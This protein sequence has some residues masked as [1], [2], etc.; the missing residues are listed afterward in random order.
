MKNEMTVFTRP[1]II[2]G[3]LILLAFVFYL[4]GISHESLWCD[5]A[6]SANMAEFGFLDIIKN[7]ALDVHPP[8]Y[9]ILLRIFRLALGNSEW[10]LRLISVFSAV[11]MIGLGA[12]PVRRLFGNKTAY[13][14]AAAV[15]FTP[16]ILIWAHEVRMYGP[17]I[18]TT[19]TCVLY[20]LSVL[21]ENK[22]RYWILFGI[23]TSAS[24]YLHYYGLIS[25][26]FINLFLFIYIVFK[27]R[28]SVKNF[29]ITAS[30]VLL[31][32]LPWLIFFFTQTRKVSN[33][34]WVTPVDIPAI[35][36]ALLQ[37]FYYKE[38]FP[39]NGMTYVLGTVLLAL[40]FGTII[41]SQIL[42]ALKKDRER[43]FMSLFIF[44]I[45]VCTFVGAIIISIFMKPVFYRR[46]ITVCTGFLI[47]PFCI[48]IGGIKFL[49]V[50]L[51]L[52]ASFI[53]LNL[54]TI[55]SVYTQKFNGLFYDIRNTYKDAIKPG[56]LVITTD[57]FCES[58]SIYYFPKADH[59]F[60]INNYEKQWEYIYDSLKPRLIKETGLEDV[61]KKYH[62]FWII[63][64][65]SMISVDASELLKNIP[66]WKR[67]VDKKDFY[68]PYSKMTFYVS[69][70]EYVGNKDKVK[71]GRIA[72]KIKGIKFK[73]GCMWISIY[74]KD[75]INNVLNSYKAHFIDVK[76]GEMTDAFD[77]VE[78]GNYVLMIQ[79]DIN[80]NQKFETDGDGIPEEGVNLINYDPAFGLNISFDKLKFKFN[81]PEKDLEL[82]VLYP[83]FDFLKDKK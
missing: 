29:I 34:F 51:M 21:K 66:G 63:N 58:T 48:G 76:D 56:D 57:C 72:V 33:A 65:Y 46:Y 26:F 13:I 19:T 10:A 74:D 23:A 75:P 45:Y 42:M 53:A 11:G 9:Y 82:Q 69:K 44:S 41:V 40:V 7:T 47:L 54:N 18:F 81:E 60:H 68:H 67:T 80:N 3:A 27:K 31:S 70:Y 8:L 50:K 17:V 22:V 61:L 37:P 38:F 73:K 4:A 35:L 16:I 83:P 71:T 39:V 55:V 43:F 20:G 52:V 2:W 62:S 5:E 32:Y 78:Y 24:A 36:Q 15:F 28:E 30:A 59:Y 77:N 64:D 25:V 14:Y 49:S 6:F 1:R 79:H 12:G